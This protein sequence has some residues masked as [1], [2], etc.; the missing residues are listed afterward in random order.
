MKARQLIGGASFPPDVLQ[1]VFEAFDD[2]WTEVSAGVGKDPGA[3][4]AAR[5][6]LATIILSLAR[7]DPIDREG[8]K[9]AAVDSFRL[10]HRL[11][12]A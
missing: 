4:E 3:V 9:A 2:A 6:S 8:L 1:V 11:K 12:G 10:K 7:T 5:L